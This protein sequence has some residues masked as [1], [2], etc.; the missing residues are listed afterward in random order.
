VTAPG[1]R[2]NLADLQ[3]QKRRYFIAKPCPTHPGP[4]DPAPTP[5]PPA[6]LELVEEED[7]ILLQS[8]RLPPRRTSPLPPS[9]LP[10][11]SPA[12]EPRE[13]LE[14]DPDNSDD[15][16]GTQ[17]ELAQRQRDKQVARGKAVPPQSEDEDAEDEQDFEREIDQHGFKDEVKRSQR[18]VKSKSV[19]EPKRKAKSKSKERKKSKKGE[20]DTQERDSDVDEPAKK[21]QRR[22]TKGKGKGKGKEVVMTGNDSTNEFDGGH[23]TG[24]LPV[25]TRKRAQ[26]LFDK[27]LQDMEAL[28]AESSKHASTLHQAV[29]S[30]LKAPRAPSPWNIWQQWNAVEHPKTSESEPS[31]AFFLS[32]TNG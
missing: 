5:S 10:P 2:I 1:P 7:S 18:A 15:D 22:K 19:S 30:V 29:G 20:K 24:P 25:E 26:E 12:A 28:A 11:S 32:G 17:R 6:P 8:P 14:S 16:Y 3:K 4:P 13:F 23:K 27:Y 9:S 21:P 31:V